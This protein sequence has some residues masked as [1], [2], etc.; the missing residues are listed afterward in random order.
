MHI[1]Y[2]SGDYI[3]SLYQGKPLLLSFFVVY[4]FFVY[5]FEVCRHLIL[6]CFAS[7]NEFVSPRICIFISSTIF[8]HTLQES[9]YYIHVTLTELCT[10][11]VHG[12][13]KWLGYEA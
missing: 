5:V 12:L 9:T 3:N 1:I 13:I 10:S 8:Q 4:K 7:V 2:R 6:F 11:Q